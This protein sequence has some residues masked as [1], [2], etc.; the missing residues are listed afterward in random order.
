MKRVYYSKNIMFIDEKKAGMSRAAAV[1]ALKAEGVDVAEYSWTLLNT[2][3]VFSEE[4]WWRHMP[5]L[6]APDSVPG[7]DEVNRTAILAPYFTS[8]QPELAEQY[9]KAFEKVWAHREEIGKA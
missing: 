3:P 6:P 8:D 5:V 7:C 2:Y 4:K 9:V 1:K